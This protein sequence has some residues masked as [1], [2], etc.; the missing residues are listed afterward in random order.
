MAAEVRYDQSVV[1]S[2]GVCAFETCIR[3]PAAA[4]HCWAGLL[5][6]LQWHFPAEDLPVTREDSE[7]K[8][9]ECIA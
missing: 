9:K 5:R 4:G 1:S 2:D 3:V 8:L 7:G 6:G